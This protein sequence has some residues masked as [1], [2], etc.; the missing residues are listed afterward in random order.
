MKEKQYFQPLLAGC[1][2]VGGIQNSEPS[3]WR[4]AYIKNNGETH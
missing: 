2:L 1:Y 3:I 4:E